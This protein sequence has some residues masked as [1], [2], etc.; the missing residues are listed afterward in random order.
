MRLARAAIDDD[1]VAVLDQGR[2]VLDVADGGNAERTRHDGDVARRAALLEHEAAQLLAVVFEQ[3]GR[4]HHARDED[5]VVW[6]IGVAR[7]E[8][9]AGELMQHAI[10]EI[11]EIMQPVAEIG[12]G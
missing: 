6:Q 7:H 11:V 9:L 2:D 12:G 3:R 1:G 4:P 5:G 8:R 10:G